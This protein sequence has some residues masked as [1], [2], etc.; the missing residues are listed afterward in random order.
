M[1]EPTSSLR[2]TTATTR[3]YPR[4]SPKCS[5]SSDPNCRRCKCPKWIYIYRDG[6]DR[7]VSARTRSWERAEQRARDIEDASDP[8][9]R[10]QRELEAAKQQ[11]DSERVTIG[12]ALERWVASK[13]KKNEETVGKY[14]TVA[15]KIQAWANE[16]PVI[17]VSEISPSML[18]Q[19]R[20]SWSPTAKR[21]DN[22]LRASTQG[23]LLERVKGFFRY[24]VGM[25]WISSS[26]A[27]NLETIEPDSGQTMPLLSGRYEQLLESTH[28]YDEVMRPDDRFGAELRVLIELMRWSGLRIGDALSCPR[29]NLQGNRLFLRKT[30][31][32]GEPVYAVLPDRLVSALRDLPKRET[33]SDKYYF[34]SGASKY[35]SL[36]CQWQRKLHRLN[37]YLDLRDDQGCPM[38]FH[39]HM[40][41]DTFA[42]E[43]LLH[44]TPLEDVSRMLGHASI[45]VTEKFYAAWVPER[46]RKL[47]AKMIAAMRRMGVEVSG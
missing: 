37:E 22:R 23:R 18:D 43:H 27:V 44:D 29:S 4:H 8:V 36:V 7:R 32:T 39:S 3:V 47:E 1:S 41:R 21:I 40:L 17:Y 9:R 42:V 31:K 11:A 20:S 45:K 46:R 12:S 35:K 34:W 13:S 6:K 16:Q 30:K 15:K 19:W 28:R 2:L 5:K 25:K 26:P 38:P 33:V 10:L 14:R 24:C